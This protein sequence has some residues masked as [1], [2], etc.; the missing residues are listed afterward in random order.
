MEFSFVWGSYYF[1]RSHRQNRMWFLPFSVFFLFFS[2]GKKATHPH[3]TAFFLCCAANLKRAVPRLVHAGVGDS[4][5]RPF[6]YVKRRRSNEAELRTRLMATRL[7]LSASRLTSY[8]M[9]PPAKWEVR[10][11]LRTLLSHQSN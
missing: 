6:T 8:R 4:R 7:Q 10:L 1:V 3:H 5:C 2:P 9:E 11:R